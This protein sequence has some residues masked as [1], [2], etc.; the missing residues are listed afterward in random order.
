[1]ILGVD[2]DPDVLIMKDPATAATELQE[3]L[4]KAREEHPE[5]FRHKP[6]FC[7]PTFVSESARA[8][9]EKEGKELKE[10]EK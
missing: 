3:K 8:L 2:R 4:R 5:R 9:E 10:E 6:S 7:P 1:M